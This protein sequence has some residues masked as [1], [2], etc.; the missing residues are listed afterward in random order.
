MI[1]LLIIVGIIF[2]SS[3]VFLY[4]IK[5]NFMENNDSV[6]SAEPVNLFVQSCL[7]QTAEKAIF[8]NSLQG[9]FFLIP[10]NSQNKITYYNM[11][12]LI[13]YP[14]DSKIASELSSYISNMIGLCLNDFSQF[15]LNGYDFME[16]P[17]NYSVSVLLVNE[18]IYVVLDLLL[19][20]KKDAFQKQYSRFEVTLPAHDFYQSILLSRQIVD[21]MQ[22]GQ[23]CL[24]C[25]SMQAEANNLTIQFFPVEA[26]EHIIEIRD[27]DYLLDNQKHLFIFGVKDE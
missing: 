27:A 9:G 10:N 4:F 17:R 13:D 19:I 16:L 21:T 22:N 15:K 14:S 24:N 1:I 8:E 7:K 26:K 6:F 18:K 11:N 20:V 3:V 25:F 5:S 12:G 2:L 23:F